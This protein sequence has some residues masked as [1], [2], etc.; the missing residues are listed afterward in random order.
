MAF[1]ASLIQYPRTIAFELQNL[2]YFF[3]IACKARLLF[4]IV[5]LHL[6]TYSIYDLA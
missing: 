5:T 1:V 3:A 2:Q 6:K 4:W